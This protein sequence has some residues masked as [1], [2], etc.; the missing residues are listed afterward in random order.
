[1][2]RNL[3]MN[4]RLSGVGKSLTAGLVP[5]IFSSIKE[6]MGYGGF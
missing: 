1:M 2:P 4:L 5:E 6:R 3:M